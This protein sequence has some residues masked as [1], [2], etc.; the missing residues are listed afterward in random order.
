MFLSLF[1]Q[2]LMQLKSLAL[3]AETELERQDEALDVLTTSTD[4]ATMHIDKHTCRMK[5]LL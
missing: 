4:Q 5:R 1:S 3:D 2:M